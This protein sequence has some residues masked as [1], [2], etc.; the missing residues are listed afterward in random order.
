MNDGRFEKAVDFVL[1]HE[2]EYNADRTVRVERDP[3]DPGGTTKFGIDQRSHPGVNIPALT[4]GQ[5]KAVYFESYWLPCRCPELPDGFAEAVF[6]VAVNNGRHEAILLLQRAIGV[7]ADGYIGPVTLARARAAG[8]AELEN[9]L[10]RRQAL[11]L[12]LATSRPRFMKYLA[13]WTNRNDDLKR[14]VLA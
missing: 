10:A 13:G 7:L 11:Y 5:A 4:Q 14:L 6:D 3:D 2:T 8:R 12:Q 9:L 1:D